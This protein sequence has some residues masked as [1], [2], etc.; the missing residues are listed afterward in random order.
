MSVGSTRPLPRKGEHLT[1]DATER[2][3]ELPGALSVAA[4]DVTEAVRVVTGYLELFDAEAAGGLSDGAQRYLGGVRDGLDHIDRLMTG[5]LSYVRAC[6]EAPEI[7]DVELDLAL[8]GAARPLRDQLTARDAR[9][10]AADLPTVRADA[11]RT[12]DLLRALISNA[13]TFASDDPLRIEVTAERD[14]DGWLITV[15]DNGIGLP[16]DA[17]ERVFKPFERA[18]SRS[19]ATGPGL[20]LAITRCVVESRGGRIW[21]ESNEEGTT[22]SFTLPD[23]EP[24]T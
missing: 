16:D 7:E 20:G 18:H 14:D 19:I 11:G 15:A 17:R 4:H 9:I 22:V 10:V 21:L 13:V 2:S 12:R 1:R 23:R 5:V 6:V 3:T 24:T 8:E